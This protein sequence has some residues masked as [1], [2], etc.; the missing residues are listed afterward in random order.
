MNF[1]DN[2]RQ[3]SIPSLL[4]LSSKELLTHIKIFQIR[5][6]ILQYNSKHTYSIYLQMN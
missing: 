5:Q 4:L 1:I 6:K 3:Q 2:R